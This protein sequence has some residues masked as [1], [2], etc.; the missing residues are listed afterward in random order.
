MAATEALWEW[1]RRYLP[2]VAAKADRPRDIRNDIT[3]P[4][5][6]AEYRSRVDRLAQ[7]V[8]YRGTATRDQ[9]S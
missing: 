9:P 3:R 5:I 6:H 2:M 1:L 4:E 7:R 8:D